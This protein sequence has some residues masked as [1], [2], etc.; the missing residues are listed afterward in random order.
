MNDVISTEFA[1]LTGTCLAYVGPG[2]GVTMLWSL[3]AILGG[4]LFMVFGLLFWPLRVLL[5]SIKKKANS[6][7]E[8]SPNLEAEDS[9]ATDD[10]KQTL[11]SSEHS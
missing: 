2:S 10:D 7:G 9:R 3:L 4:I 11:P 5:R 8:S 1:H 6:R